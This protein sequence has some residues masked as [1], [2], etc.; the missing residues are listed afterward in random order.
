MI[1]LPKVKENENFESNKKN[2]HHQ[3]Q[4]C[5]ITLSAVF[6]AKSLQARREWNDIFKVMKTNKKQNT[7]SQ[8][9]FIQQKYPSKMKEI[10]TFPNSRSIFIITRST[11][12]RILN[13]IL[14][15]KTK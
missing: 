6:S 11:L 13:E 8:E 3:V 2:I 12:E 10:K 1:I 4:K 15:F 9:Y 14:Q 5:P 7:A